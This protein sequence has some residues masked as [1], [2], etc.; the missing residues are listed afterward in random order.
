MAQRTPKT[1]TGSGAPQPA[2]RRSPKQ[3][4]FPAV[5]FE[6]ALIL[7]NAIQKMAGGAKVR[8]LTLFDELGKS[9]ESGPSRQLITNSGRYGLTTGS[10]KAEWIELT[11]LGATSTNPDAAARERTRARFQLA[12]ENVQ[13]F[14]LLYDQFKGKKMPAV[15][16]MRDALKDNFP[17]G[18][19]QECVETFTV[20]AKFVGLLRPIGGAERLLTIEHVLDEL[21]PTHPTNG[22]AGVAPARAAQASEDLDMSEGDGDW[23]NLCFYITPIGEDETEERRHSDLF[24]G[25]V[26]EPAIESLGLRVVRADRISSSGLI[27]AQIIEHVLKARLVV[28]DLSFHNPNV[29]Y[30]LALRHFTSKPTIH[31]CRAS[32]RMP[33]DL[34]Q[35]RT[36]RLDMTDIYTFVP[37]LE[38]WRT[39]ITSYARRA[40]DGDG[41]G[42]PL[43]VFYPDFAAELTAV[44]Q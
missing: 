40:L 8:R 34:S 30:E 20:N 10:Y 44:A 42:N 4:S 18:E 24:L 36:V 22:G 16:V 5:P 12:I 2:K 6:D 39:E 17:D 23:A 13:P 19:L 33:F 43:T 38:T 15:A 7:A 1:T 27:T 37:Q 11:S 26:V 3:R 25:S 31:I 29:F 14:K 35:M 21:P 32:D 41:G 28:A 9:P